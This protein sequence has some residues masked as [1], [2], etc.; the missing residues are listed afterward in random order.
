[1]LLSL[2][3][4]EPESSKPLSSLMFLMEPSGESASGD[5]TS[6]MCAG[7]AS[8]TGGPSGSPGDDSR[9]GA[10]DKSEEESRACICGS[11]D[12]GD[13]GDCTDKPRL[14]SAT[15]SWARPKGSILSKSAAAGGA[16]ATVAAGAAAAA[17][18]AVEARGGE[19]LSALACSCL[20]RS[21]GN[22]SRC[23]PRGSI[24]TVRFVAVVVIKA[25]EWVL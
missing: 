24:L 6:S 23:K 22:R 19:G 7:D 14:S 10:G 11:D 21:S 12:S 8:G 2:P 20:A 25:L 16:S 9:G 5:V 17:A 1:L 13:S 4:P 3:L 15:G 18:G